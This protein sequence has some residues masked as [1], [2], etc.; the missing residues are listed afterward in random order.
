[1]PHPCR[2]GFYGE[3]KD[4]KWVPGEE[5]VAE[6]YDVPIPG[7]GTKTCRQAPAFA[8]YC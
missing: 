1:V 8:L 3:L 2:V 5:V 6:A 4:G 7:Y